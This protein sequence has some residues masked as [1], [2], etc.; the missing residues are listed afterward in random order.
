MNTAR[1]KKESAQAWET[2]KRLPLTV[3]N[4]GGLWCDNL[5][6]HFAVA[7][8]AEESAKA[9]SRRACSREGCEKRNSGG[10][11]GARDRAREDRKVAGDEEMVVL[12]APN[13]LNPYVKDCNNVE[14]RYGRALVPRSVADHYMDVLDGYSV[15]EE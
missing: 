7:L 1:G 4:P 6:P 13:C 5:L 8:A 10:K 12:L 14:F 3:T 2:A 9:G 11:G 15:E